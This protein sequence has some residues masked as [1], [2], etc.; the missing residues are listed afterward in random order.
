MPHKDESVQL[1]FKCT[2]FAYHNSPLHLWL[3]SALSPEVISSKSKSKI[4]STT[5]SEHDN[6]SQQPVC[7]TVVVIKTV[8]IQLQADP[9]I[10]YVA[11]YIYDTIQILIFKHY[12]KYVRN[13]AT[14][15]Q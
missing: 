15:W 10:I 2:V 11:V 9:F 6:A 12:M 4:T 8:H 5:V 14:L 1:Q 13:S 3:H 7:H